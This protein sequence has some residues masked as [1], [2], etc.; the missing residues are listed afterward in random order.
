LRAAR[1]QGRAFP[2]ALT[3]AETL[4]DLSPEGRQGL[5]RLHH[6]LHRIT[7]HG[8]AW[9]FLSR[10]LFETSDYLR[11]ILTDTSL[12]AAKTR[13]GIY[14]LLATAQGTAKR[15]ASEATDARTGFL[16]YLRLLMACG[17][18][19]SIRPPAEA[20]EID[21]VRIMTVHQS[22]GLEFPVVYLPNLV[23]GQFP[24]RRGSRM[25][26]P[27]PELLRGADSDADVDE[28]EGASEDCLFF[29]AL[30]RAR[31][32]LVLSRPRIWKS[33]PARRASYWLN[34]SQC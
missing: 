15:F 10:Y 7:Y 27:P 31:D 12:A 26:A 20:S 8:D 3:L 11:P 17:Q 22:K 33:R 2:A 25:A 5:L 18:E 9:R 23:E 24:P 1:E 16:A 6:D 19:R 4:P 13:L 32:Q 34:W 28:G 21:G 14:Q 29:V 30:S